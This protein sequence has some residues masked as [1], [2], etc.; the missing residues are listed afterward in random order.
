[1]E[2]L[3]MSLARS[4]ALKIKIQNFTSERSLGEYWYQPL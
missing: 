1:M 2:A 3:K 4:L